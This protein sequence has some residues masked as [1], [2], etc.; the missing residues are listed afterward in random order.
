MYEASFV[1]LAYL[2]V[3]FFRVLTCL[4]C[5]RT[6]GAGVVVLTYKVINTKDYDIFHFI[7][8]RE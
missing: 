3:D 8:K 7:F 1:H 6:A 4:P 2:M 5:G